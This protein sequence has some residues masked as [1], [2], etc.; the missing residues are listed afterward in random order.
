MTDI[1]RG[2]SKWVKVEKGSKI[3]KATAHYYIELSNYYFSLAEFSADPRPEDDQQTESKFKRE[4][5]Q[6]RTKNK[7]NKVKEYFSKKSKHLEGMNDDE[8]L[9]F[10]IT[11]EEDERTV[12]AKNDHKI[13][14][15]KMDAAHTFKGKATPSLQQKMKN[16]G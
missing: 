8:I 13:R 6:R 7:I 15:T 12:M 11:K 5:A 2:N 10:Y 4:A 9:D 1:D 16:T 3:T 14:W